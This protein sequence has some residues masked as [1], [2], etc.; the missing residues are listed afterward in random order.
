MS[1][2]YLGTCVAKKMGERTKIR[3]QKLRGKY[4]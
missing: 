4:A 2:G 1:T 3:R